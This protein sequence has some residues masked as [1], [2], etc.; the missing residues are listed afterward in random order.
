MNKISQL[1]A[2]LVLVLS[3]L[4]GC[5]DESRAAG[6]TNPAYVA[7]MRQ[8]FRD[9]WVGHIY[10]VQHVVPNN[11]MNDAEERDAVERA[12]VANTK[13]I[14]SMITPF[15]GEAA[16][17][18]FLSLLDIHDDALRAY[19]EATV[20]GDMPRQDAALVRLEANADDFTD[21][22]SRLNPYLQKDNIRSL[23]AVHGADHVFQ[24][25]LY[26]ERK[27]ARLW[28]ASRKS[29]RHAYVIADALTTAFV[30]QFPSQFS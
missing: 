10:W 23:I 24:I 16:S 18:K 21:F 4:V 14:A 2:L 6:D 19:A 22:F 11:T 28:G 13:R 17:Q 12:I 29:R 26:S 3:G 8:A 25:S 1:L 27:Y 30:K 20:A 9:L 15:Y 7:E 5:D